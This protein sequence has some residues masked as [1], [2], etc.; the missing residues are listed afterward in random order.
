MRK[1]AGPITSLSFALAA[2]VGSAAAMAQAQTAAATIK[3]DVG[4]KVYD[5]AGVELG[6]IASND[7]NVVVIDFGGRQAALPTNAFAQTDKG[8]A[9]SVTAAQLTAALDQQAAATTAALDAA[10]Q[11]G[12]S[13]HGVN[14]NAVVGKVKLADAEEV[15]VT[16]DKGEVR[17]PRK[18]FFLSDKGLS[19]SFT[20]SQFA[21]AV[22]E[23][24]NAPAQGDAATEA[25]P[26]EEPAPKPAD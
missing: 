3:L 4:A 26:P 25:T 13:I 6:P 23:T 19:V 15:L 22:A 11:P 24:A 17:L 14:G 12:T 18:A 10:L 8:L 9:I 7:G 2:T 5:S 20:A 16:T 1:Y 21:A